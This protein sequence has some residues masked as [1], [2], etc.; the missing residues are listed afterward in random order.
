MLLSIVCQL[1]GV[2]KGALVRSYLRDGLK[3]SL[4][5]TKG[6]LID[7]VNQA[8]N[9]GADLDALDERRIGPGKRRVRYVTD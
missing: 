8:L 1:Q 5:D 4:K 2:S 6:T 3:E 7:K 9:S